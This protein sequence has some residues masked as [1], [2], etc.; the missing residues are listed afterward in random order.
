MTPNSMDD[1]SPDALPDASLT[2]SSEVA[3]R[4]GT[5]PLH[6]LSTQEAARRLAQD[7]PNAL[8]SAPPV[9]A[10]RRLLAQFRDPLLIRPQ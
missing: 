10:W 1:P 2:D 8:Q 4:L 5:D 9:P 7:G 3:Q 6:G